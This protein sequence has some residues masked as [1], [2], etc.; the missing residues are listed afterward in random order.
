MKKLFL[1]S[2]AYKVLDKFVELLDSPPSDLIV[3]FIPT[4]ADVYKDKTFIDEDRNK[5]TELGFKI[6]EINISGKT[7][8][9][10]R[11]KF[12][13]VDIIFVAGGNTFYLLEK[14]LSS[15]FDKII[16]EHVKKGKYYIGSSAGSVIAGTSIEPVKPID[17][18]T[19]APNLKSFNGLNLIDKIILPHYGN[20]KYQ[21]KINKILNDY[22]HSNVKIIKLTDNQALFVEGKMLKVIT[23]DD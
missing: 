11:E 19:K 5:L 2:N 3:A 14:T 23:S 20:E 12:K 22:T 6:L 10:L 16:K 18:P 1:A 9:T 8:K 21:E 15:G 7:E 17:D 13:D 4:A